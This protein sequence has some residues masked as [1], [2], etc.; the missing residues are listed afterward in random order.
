MLSLKGQHVIIFEGVSL[1]SI[2]F[3]HIIEC[4]S[5]LLR[6][7][8]PG[9]IFVNFVGRGDELKVLISE[10]GS[11]SVNPLKASWVKK[12]HGAVQRVLRTESQ[13]QLSGVRDAS[14]GQ[15]SMISDLDKIYQT[16]AAPNEIT[17]EG[18]A[19]IRGPTDPL[20]RAE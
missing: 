5:L 20:T 11:L 1:P 16:D 6:L 12:Q 7:F 8:Y 4:V 19:K 10:S 17:G 2:L 14:G 15:H 3:Y 9:R 18:T 13:V